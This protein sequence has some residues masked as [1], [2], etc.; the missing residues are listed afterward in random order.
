M[1]ALT[2]RQP[3]AWAV[4]AGHKTVENRVW[5]TRH[6]GPLAIHAGSGR[7]D[8]F[9]LADPRWRGLFGSD[10]RPELMTRGAVVGV[11]DVIDCVPADHPSVRDNPWT[12]GPWCWILANARPVATPL[13][14]RGRLGLFDVTIPA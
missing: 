1:K 11:V 10:F 8:L 14:M 12:I 6:R 4:V 2:I 5:P 9:V 7:G 3:W 13:Q